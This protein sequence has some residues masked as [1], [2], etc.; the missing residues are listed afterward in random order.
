MQD[1]VTA[2]AFLVILI[3]PCVVASSVRLSGDEE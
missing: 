3:A 2:L 1:I